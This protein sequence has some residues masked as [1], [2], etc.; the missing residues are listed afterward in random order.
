MITNLPLYHKF[1][2]ESKPMLHKYGRV[3]Q[4]NIYI[5]AKACVNNNVIIKTP[6]N[7]DVK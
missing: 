6:I 5:K 4:P 7:I 2:I 1:V 3:T